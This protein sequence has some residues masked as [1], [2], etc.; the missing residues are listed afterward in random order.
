M[1]SH[2]FMSMILIGFAACAPDPPADTALAL[3]FGP[4]D[5]APAKTLTAHAL[6]NG[7]PSPETFKIESG[8]ITRLG[9]RFAASYEGLLHID[10]SADDASGCQVWAG[11]LERQVPAREAIDVTLERVNPPRCP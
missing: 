9:V 8:P 1:R 11:A 6:L 2:L 4:G 3:S 7:K 5:L 10:I